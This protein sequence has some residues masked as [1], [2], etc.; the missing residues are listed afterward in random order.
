MNLRR[1]GFL[2]A[3]ILACSAPLRALAAVSTLP[4]HDMQSGDMH[5]HGDQRQQHDQQK[6]HGCGSCLACCAGAAMSYLTPLLP[7]DSPVEPAA[8]PAAHAF[9]GA[10]PA[11]LDR[12]PQ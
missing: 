2:M 1:L 7:A 11:R 4:C 6:A 3:L 12:P 9:S 5:E 10:P 8:S